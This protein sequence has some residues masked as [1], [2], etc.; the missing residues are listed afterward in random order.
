MHLR[1]PHLP[2]IVLYMN[3][4][5]PSYSLLNDY[6]PRTTSIHSSRWTVLCSTA[7][8]IAAVAAALFTVQGAWLLSASAEHRWRFDSYW[9]P[10][11]CSMTEYLFMCACGIVYNPSFIFSE[12]VYLD[13]QRRDDKICI[14]TIRDNEKNLCIRLG[15]LI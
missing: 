9:F 11:T 5:S 14:D 13:M 6:I 15:L 10:P 4:L 8:V 12:M 2:E 1:L 3:R 7:V